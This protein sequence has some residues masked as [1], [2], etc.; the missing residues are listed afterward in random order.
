MRPY[1]KI[2]RTQ[3]NKS[4]K[5]QERKTTRTRNSK[6]SNS[7]N[8]KEIRLRRRLFP[9]GSTESRTDLPVRFHDHIRPFKPR[10]AQVRPLTLL[11]AHNHR[12][13]PALCLPLAFLVPQHP[14]FVVIN[15]YRIFFFSLGRSYRGDEIVIFLQPRLV[16]LPRVY[17]DRF[18]YE[19]H[20]VLSPSEVDDSER[21]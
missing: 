12:H 2:T 21:G 4:A 10:L 3:N 14:I 15:G 7:K 18:A 19:I 9:S 11:Q 16:S 13:L 5:Q 20:L 17:T 1:N 8:S 6:H